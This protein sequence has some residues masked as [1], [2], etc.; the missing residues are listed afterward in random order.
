[1]EVNTELLEKTMQHIKDNPDQ[2]M[3]S[4]WCNPAGGAFN[5]S[6]ETTAC[7]AGWAMILS[8]KYKAH[9]VEELS[10]KS[11][12][13]AAELLGISWEEACLMFA[14]ARS[15]VELELMVK[16]LLNGERLKDDPNHYYWEARRNA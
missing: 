15:R 6:C 10:A 1:M 9:Q 16:D 13:V 2:H 11:Q 3:Q 5:H 8:G 4:T 7:F 14:P 12:E